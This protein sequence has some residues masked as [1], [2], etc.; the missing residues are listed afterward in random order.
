MLL[1][2]YVG[3]SNVVPTPELGA[4]HTDPGKDVVYLVLY[5]ACALALAY[6]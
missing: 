2:A 3:H 6:K 4:Y 1:T 5:E